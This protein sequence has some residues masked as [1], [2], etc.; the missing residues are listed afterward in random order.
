LHVIGA[1]SLLEFELDK[2]SVPVG[3]LEFIYVRPFTFLDVG[4]MQCL[5]GIR[6]RDWSE[7]D[8]LFSAHTGAVA[9]QFVGQEL[10]C[11][12]GVNKNSDLYYWDRTARGSTAEIDYLVAIS[13]NVIPL[14]VKSSAFGYLKRLHLF[15]KKYRSIPLGLKISEQK[16]ARKER[17]AA[18]PLY[19][20]LQLHDLYG[21]LKSDT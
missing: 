15:L 21:Q 13:G 7:S 3:R 12:E 14:E 1:G 18:A 2:I 9:E 6:Y 17:I 10:I 16:I 19:S 4:L 20:V 5:M 11:L 8:N